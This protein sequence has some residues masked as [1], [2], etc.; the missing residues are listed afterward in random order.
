MTETIE[1]LVSA[2]EGRFDDIQRDYSVEDVKKLDF[3]VV[4]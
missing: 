1:Q 2:Q 4:L 3:L